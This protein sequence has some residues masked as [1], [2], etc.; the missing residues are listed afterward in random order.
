MGLHKLP[1]V[2][3]Q[4]PNLL[5]THLLH[6]I[7]V[8]IDGYNLL[9]YLCLKE[10]GIQHGRWGGEYDTFACK[11]RSFFTNLKA[12]NIWCFVVFSGARDLRD[13]QRDKS[14]TGHER[15]IEMAGRIFHGHTTQ[16]IM[17][18]FAI[19]VLQSVLKDLHIP[20]AISDFKSTNEIVGLANSWLCPILAT[21]P[22]YYLMD[23]KAGF[24][25][26]DSIQWQNIQ[27]CDIPDP[28]GKTAL[29]CTRY[30]L[31]KFCHHFKL[32]KTLVPLLRILLT[33]D[34]T[35]QD[36]MSFKPQNGITN[37]VNKLCEQLASHKSM[38]DAVMKLVG[39]LPMSQRMGIQDQIQQSLESLAPSNACKLAAYFT[40]KKITS[41][42]QLLSDL[43]ALPSWCYEYF[44]AGL[45]PNSIINILSTKQVF[46]LVHV[47]D[48]TLPSSNDLA[49]PLRRVLY[50]ILLLLDSFDRDEAPMITEYDR[51][52]SK[53]ACNEI[54]PLYDIPNYGLTLQIWDVDEVPVPLRRSF[55]LAAL[56]IDTVNFGRMLRIIPAIFQLPICVVT[57]WIQ[58]SWMASFNH[59]RA[60][61]VCWIINIAKMKSDRQD[62]NSKVKDHQYGKDQLQLMDWNS[63]EAPAILYKFD[64]QIQPTFSS[65]P[66]DIK[67]IYCFSQL[68]SCMK[69]SLHLNAALQH[70]FATPDMTIFY[71]G[72]LAHNIYYLLGSLEEGYY[73]EWIEAQLFEGAPTAAVLYRVMIGFIY[74]HNRIIDE[75]MDFY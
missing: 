2:I 66:E 70:A 52:D 8:I 56:E 64:E 31:S 37:D 3:S 53:L 71:N 30:L 13:T 75:I 27:I 5:Q 26:L 47:D 65:S 42:P 15:R 10:Q 28:H 50:G 24:V 11:C 18:V 32:G 29:P 61:L 25:P 23:I 73:D 48:Q 68:Q 72:N 67:P 60:L 33:D 41:H 17:P 54:P 39:H 34:I 1:A 46:T 16:S 63:S 6:N 59:A 12:C 40:E 69:T 7:R 20:F 36:G 43:P 57:Y 55:L 14:V 19:E 74:A 49:L 62:I 58:N 45:L 4:S 44:R 35:K 22:S 38:P 9:T 21:D 51:V